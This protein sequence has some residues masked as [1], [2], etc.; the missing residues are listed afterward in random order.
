MGGAEG[1]VK[2]F[3]LIL[4]LACF[5]APDAAH[6]I[7]AGVAKGALNVG[8][9][10]IPL[11]HAYAQLH[12]NAEKLL[13]RPRE[14]RILLADREAPQ[15]ALNGIAFLPVVHMAREGKLRG[16]LI[17]LDPAKPDEAAV[18]VLHAPADAAKCTTRSGSVRRFS[19]SHGSLRISQARRRRTVRRLARCATRS[20][21]LR[22]AT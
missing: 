8:G 16:L 21:R 20:E 17:Q 7:D 4:S 1:A 10:T 3:L 22:K 14:L 19:P 5:H 15:S 13:E 11:T 12:D 9:A 18:T 6:A 2:T